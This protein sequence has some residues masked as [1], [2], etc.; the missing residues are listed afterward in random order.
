MGRDALPMRVEV[1]DGLAGAR[2]AL[3]RHREGQGGNSRSWIS[4]GT[5][6]WRMAEWMERGSD[7]LP[8]PME[9]DDR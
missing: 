3:V 7:A 6:G 1:D 4:G 2:G 8:G 5:D 9:V